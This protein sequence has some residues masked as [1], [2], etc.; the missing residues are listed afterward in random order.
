MKTSRILE[1]AWKV[2][3]ESWKMDKKHKG[4]DSERQ[5]VDSCP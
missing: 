2:E 5:I 3:G 4:C 1:Y